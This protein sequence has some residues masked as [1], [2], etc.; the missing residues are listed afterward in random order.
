MCMAGFPLFSP[1]C[2]VLWEPI[3]SAITHVQNRK[4]PAQS[5]TIAEGS[6]DAAS[7]RQIQK[8]PQSRRRKTSSFPRVLT[9]VVDVLPR[10]AASSSHSSSLRQPS[11]RAS[12]LSSGPR[13]WH[14][15][16]REAL[17]RWDGHGCEVD[18]LNTHMKTSSRHNKPKKSNN[19]KILPQS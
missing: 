5:T 15:D 10:T 9:L 8:A 12:S 3:L 18:S 16:C 2:F 6:A 4:H 13:R 17:R 11:S 14:Q 19:A 7:L 1:A